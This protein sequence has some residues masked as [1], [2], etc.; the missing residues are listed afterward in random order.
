M[1]EIA[2]VPLSGGLIG[3]SRAPGRHG[4][5]AGDLAALL[6]WHPDLVLTMTSDIELEAIGA[7]TLAA[8][9]AKSSI[10]W[11]HFPVTDFRAPC[12]KAIAEWPSLE[13]QVMDVLKAGGKV[14]VHCYGGCG[15]SGMAVL[16]LMVDNGEERDAAIARLR[17]ARPGAVESLAQTSWACETTPT[18][19][20][21]H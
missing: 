21:A 13:A 11:R 6:D 7:D 5:Y 8:D 9:L 12:A 18:A 4:D 15:R 10:S 16:K 2:E 19:I 20:A 14:L 17:A 3:L 1:F